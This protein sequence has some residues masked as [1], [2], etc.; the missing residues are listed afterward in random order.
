MKGHIAHIALYTHG[1][2]MNSNSIINTLK[3]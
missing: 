1:F 3:I 2:N